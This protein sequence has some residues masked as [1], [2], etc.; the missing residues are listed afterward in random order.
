MCWSAQHVPAHHEARDASRLELCSLADGV[1]QLLGSSM[2]ETHPRWAGCRDSPGSTA[3][4]SHPPGLVMRQDGR[5][6]ELACSEPE[7]SGMAVSKWRRLNR[8]IGKTPTSH[9][10]GS[11][12]KHITQPCS[13]QG[14]PADVGASSD[15]RGGCLSGCWAWASPAWAEATSIVNCPITRL[16]LFRPGRDGGE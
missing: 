9:R 16:S 10:H 7:L 15:L 6:E 2:I 13:W 1:E 14:V 12:Y 11:L 5:K 8:D 4:G 3:G